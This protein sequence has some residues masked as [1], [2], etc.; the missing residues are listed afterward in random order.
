MKISVDR[1]RCIGSGNCSFYAPGTFTLDD[2]LKVQVIEGAATG[3]R[4]AAS[5]VRAAAEGCPVHAIQIEEES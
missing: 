4:D 5:D 1:E 2:D 3:D